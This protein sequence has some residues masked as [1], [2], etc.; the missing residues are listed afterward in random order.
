[1][2]GLETGSNLF[3]AEIA[4]GNAAILTGPNFGA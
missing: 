2:K 4:G 3:P 1:M